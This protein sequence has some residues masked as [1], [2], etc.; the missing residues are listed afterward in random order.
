MTIVKI[1]ELVGVSD[2]G[3]QDAVE[4]AV[5]RAA[6]SLRNIRGVD[7]LNWTAKVKDGKIMEYRANIKISF[8]VEKASE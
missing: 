7:V 8:S 4:Q 6:E 5:M 1:V 2:K 3:W